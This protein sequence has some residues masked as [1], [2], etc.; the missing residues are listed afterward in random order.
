MWCQTRTSNVGA[1]TGCW[2]HMSFRC[3]PKASTLGCQ[4]QLAQG[5]AT[6]FHTVPCA[7]Y[8]G[9]EQQ[10]AKEAARPARMC[11]NAP[12]HT[13]G[14]CSHR[15]ETTVVCR[16]SSV[17]NASPGQQCAPHHPGL[18]DM[19][20]LLWVNWLAFDLMRAPALLRVC[21]CGC[22][23]VC[24]WLCVCGVARSTSTSLCN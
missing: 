8:V 7:C 15:A 1:Y 9:S 2:C 4:L 14:T 16:A 20:T 21:V 6:V 17:L 12:A 24:V 19:C 18:I 5:A 3:T 10:L 13:T 23:C 22:V 11:H